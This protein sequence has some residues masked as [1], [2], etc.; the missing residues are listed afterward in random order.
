[1][2][3]IPL[4]AGPTPVDAANRL[5]ERLGMSAR[6][7][8]KRDDAIPF[9]AG[10]NKV[11]KLEFVAGRA[12]ADAADTLVTCGGV[13]SNHCRV[14]AA[15]AARL[16]LD[17]VLVVNGA[18]PASA[19]LAQPSSARPGTNSSTPTTVQA[20]EARLRQAGIGEGATAKLTGNALLVRLFG[21]RVES[22]ATRDER[23]PRM[24]QV[25]EELRA[26]QRRPFAIP[27]GA[28]TPLGA[29]SYIRAVRELL[30]Q[31]PAPDLIIHASSSAG[32]QAGLIAG[33]AL[34]GVKTR[35][36]GVSA[37]DPADVLTR[38]IRD[39]IGGIPALLTAAQP[40]SGAAGPGLNLDPARLTGDID[41]DAD[42]VG[43][44]YGVP[45]E[46]STEAIALAASCEGLLVDPVY[47]AKALAALIAYARAGRFSADQTVL[48]WH[49]GGIPG[50]FA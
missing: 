3:R 49:T 41:V 5:R 19:G 21:A 9:G 38:T 27:L 8:I 32:T 35:V 50:L 12:L 31:I 14:T 18:P 25:V 30:Q 15:L 20:S 22:V 37:D 45:T 40:E 47:G 46:A 24:A 44:G 23:A 39:I 7:L 16:G 34:H 26:R 36:I 2:P 11:R 28:S 10:G 33:C 1:L 42:F 13:Q 29:L 48:F 43:G 6:L 4:L 17:C